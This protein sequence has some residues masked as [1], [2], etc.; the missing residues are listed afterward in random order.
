MWAGYAATIAPTVRSE[1]QTSNALATS[2]PG[3]R[4]GPS[5]GVCGRTPV[6]PISPK[7]S[8]FLHVFFW[9]GHR[10]GSSSRRN[11]RWSVRKAWRRPCRSAWRDWGGN[12]VNRENSLL[13][14]LL[15]LAQPSLGGHPQRSDLLYRI[16][17]R[18]DTSHS[19]TT[20][21]PAGEPAARDSFR[22]IAN[23]RVYR[24]AR[25]GALLSEL[26]CYHPV[27]NPGPHLKTRTDRP[28]RW[29]F[30]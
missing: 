28:T 21:A 30:R 12:H 29:S 20:S 2:G 4:A 26:W 23:P 8:L 19:H 3:L 24:K 15:P 10:D 27:T 17:I 7:R 9:P 18:M 22:A 1:T 16:T 11:R 25:P 13:S 14:P 5:G 6:I